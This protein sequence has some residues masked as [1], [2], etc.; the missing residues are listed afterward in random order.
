MTFLVVLLSLQNCQ[1]GRLA[2]VT[3]SSHARGFKFNSRSGRV[4]SALNPHGGRVNEE[5]L[6]SSIGKQRMTAVEDSVEEEG[7]DRH[8]TLCDPICMLGPVALRLGEKAPN[9]TQIVL[10]LLL[11]PSIN[12]A[13]YWIWTASCMLNDYV[14]RRFTDDGGNNCDVK[15]DDNSE[16]QHRHE[17]PKT[18]RNSWFILLLFSCTIDSATQCSST[19]LYM[20]SSYIFT[21]S[22]ASSHSTLAASIYVC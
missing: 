4:D 12:N 14:V 7:C 18:C 2:K 1:C 13:R 21:A 3:A 15:A 20:P 9:A 17:S 8:V 16:S 5:Q 10:C 11:Q 6:A 19:M 22:S